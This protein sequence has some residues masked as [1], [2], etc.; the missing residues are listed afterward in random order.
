MKRLLAAMALMAF[1]MAG[2]AATL[3]SGE[4]LRYTVAGKDSTS[5]TFSLPTEGLTSYRNFGGYVK[6]SE[7]EN[8]WATAND[9][10]QNFQMGHYA[11]SWN[12]AF[13]PW[14]QSVIQSSILLDFGKVVETAYVWVR[15]THGAGNLEYLQFAGQPADPGAIEGD[16]GLGDLETPAAVPLPGA[17][18]LLLSGVAGLGLMRRHQRATA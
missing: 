2:S 8:G 5:I 14:G 4:W 11:G 1:P 15:S 16:E 10:A 7:F 17:L 18:V 6:W 9:Y 13:D 12:L 3:N